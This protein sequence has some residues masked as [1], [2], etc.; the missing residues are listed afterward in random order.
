MGG[1]REKILLRST[2]PYQDSRISGLASEWCAYMKS[3]QHD[4][5]ANPQSPDLHL[6]TLRM[7]II[8]S[9]AA[10]AHDALNRLRQHYKSYGAQWSGLAYTWRYRAC[11]ASMDVECVK[12]ICTALNHRNTSQK[13]WHA[14]NGLEQS[15]RQHQQSRMP[16]FQFPGLPLPPRTLHPAKR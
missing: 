16:P 6:A 13:N 4:Y 8:A 5:E 12:Q 15:S 7:S 9:T 14:R 11:G 3:K 2:T 10:T 1:E